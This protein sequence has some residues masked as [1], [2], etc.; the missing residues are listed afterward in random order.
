MA[1]QTTIGITRARSALPQAKHAP[2]HAP[3]LFKG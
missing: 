1:L 3:F 2:E